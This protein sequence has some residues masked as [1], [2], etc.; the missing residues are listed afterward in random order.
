ME[1]ANQQFS[2]RHYQSILYALENVLQ[3][4]LAF[5]FQSFDYTLRQFLSLQLLFS[6]PKQS[7]LADHHFHHTRKRDALAYCLLSW[8][9]AM[10]TGK[11]PVNN[12]S[13]RQT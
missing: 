2:L 5:Q 9:Y 1:Q 13:T 10:K 12:I 4:L 3:A 7:L 8:Q 6:K 11:E